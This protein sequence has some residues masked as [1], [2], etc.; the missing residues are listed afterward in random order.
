MNKLPAGVYPAIVTPFDEAGNID[1]LSLVRHLAWLESK[2]CVGVTLAGTTGEGPSLSAVEKRDMLRIAKS[3]AGGLKV[4]LGVLTSSLSEAKWMVQ[5]AGKNGADAILL[6]PPSYFR[7]ASVTGVTEWLQDVMDHSPLPVLLYNFPKM[8]GYGF[9]VES[10]SSLRVHPKFAGLKDSS[11]VLANLALFRS[12][13]G[14]DDSLFVGD[15]TLLLSAMEAGW[16]GSISGAANVVPQWLSRLIASWLAGDEASARTL[17]EL[18]LQALVAIRSCPQ[19]ETHKAV[20]KAAGLL[21]N[22]SPRLPLKPV[23]VDDRWDI[24]LSRLGDPFG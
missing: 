3:A 19:P 4:I 9:S 21:S 6:M 14:P 16:T 2:G 13:V 17:F 24:L 10:L 20:L 12:L 8:S 5:Q 15:E 22:D 7:R 23:E 1:A 11:G 18:I